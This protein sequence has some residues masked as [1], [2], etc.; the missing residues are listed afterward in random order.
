MM[1]SFFVKK[2]EKKMIGFKAD[3]TQ[4]ASYTDMRIY[5]IN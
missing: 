5:Y 1:E 2:I 4:N 3:Q